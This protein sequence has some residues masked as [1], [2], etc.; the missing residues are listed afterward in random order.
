MHPHGKENDPSRNKNQYTRG[1]SQSEDQAAV[2]WL[3]K[4]LQHVRDASG[5]FECYELPKQPGIDVNPAGYR[6]F[7][8]KG[9]KVLVHWFI[10]KQA[11]P[12]IPLAASTENKGRQVSH[13]C[14]NRACCRVSH[15]I[16]ETRQANMARIG[17]KGYLR[18]I[19]DSATRSSCMHDPHCKK[20][21]DFAQ[22]SQVDPLP[23]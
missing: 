1:S 13:L 21:T 12:T 20:V 7:S 18:A 2:M 23:E 16:A 3:Q 6:R 19:E 15:L 8:H 10:F 11:N 4:K 9:R 22:F 5:Y 17:C 14:G